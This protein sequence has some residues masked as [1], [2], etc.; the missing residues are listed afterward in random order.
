MQGWNQL[1]RRCGLKRDQFRHPKGRSTRRKD[2]LRS[3]PATPYQNKN[4]PSVK[5]PKIQRILYEIS[6]IIDLPEHDAQIPLQLRTLRLSE[7][8]EPQLIYFL[9]YSR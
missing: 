6:T 4:G 8:H 7:D 3:Q 5:K 9:S 2:R 1:S